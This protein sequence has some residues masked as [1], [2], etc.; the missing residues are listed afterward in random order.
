MV[1]VQVLM[2]KEEREEFRRMAQRSGMSLSSWLR[3]AGLD[4]MAR[5][6]GAVEIDSPKA[7]RE[8]FAACDERESGIEPDWEEHKRVIEG[9]KRSGDSQT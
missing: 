7:L 4:R 1:R 2:E 5:D 3:Q 8:F 6:A 9:S